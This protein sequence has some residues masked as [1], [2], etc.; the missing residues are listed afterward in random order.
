[1]NDPATSFQSRDRKGAVADL[2]WWLAP[3]LFLFVLYF[4]GLTAW[5]A[6]DDFAWLGLLRQVRNFHD[7]LRVMFAPAAQG[8]IRFWSERGF[9][10]LFEKLFGLDS[11]PF[12]VWVFLTMAANVALVAWITRRITGS[13]MAGFLAP[14]LWTMNTSLTLVMTWTSAYNEAL[15]SLFLLSATALLIRYAETGRRSFWWWQLVVFTLGFGALEL[16]AVYPAIAAAYVLFVAPRA[17]RRKLL[18]SLIPLFCIS[19][20]YFLLHRAVAPFLNEGPYA[21]TVDGRILHTLRWYLKLSILPQNWVPFGHSA[22]SGKAIVAIVALPLAAFFVRQIA[23]GR[24]VV[25][26]FLSWFLFAIAPMLSLPNHLSDYYLTVPS[27]GLA[28]AGA[29]GIATAWRSQRIFRLAAVIPLVAYAWVMIP[30]TRTAVSWWMDRVRPIRGLVLGVQAAQNSHPGKTI[31]LDGITSAL[32]DDTIASSAF[33]PLGLDNVY[34]TPESRDRIHPA[35]NPEKLDE[36]V[37]EPGVMRSAITHEQVVVYFFLGDHLRNITREYERSA[38]TRLVDSEPRR[39]EIGNPLFGYL[40]GPEWSPPASGFRW[41]PRRATVRLAGPI[42]IKDRMRLVGYCPAL[43]L[44]GG[45]LHLFLTVD[46]IPL[47]GTQINDPDAVF[48]R[49]FVLPPSLIG[50]KTI[51]VEISV[52]RATPGPNGGELGVVVDTISIQPV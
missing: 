24:N 10:L 23:Q 40:L 9:F 3:V 45:P 25:L 49:L 47:E 20:V 48:D 30:S 43:Q 46:G 12:R 37:M 19:G 35:D 33:F 50:R 5:F 11:L 2:A 7:F 22:G 42:S 52:D 18:L 26:F 16:N 14:F 27:I 15:C 31:V 39:V 1:V 32:F 28:M 41:M 17:S 13:R 6:A 51:H 44:R 38:L 34:L 36:V 21:V 4:K 8:T 29:L